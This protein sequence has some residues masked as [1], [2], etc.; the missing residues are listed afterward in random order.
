MGVEKPKDSV[1]AGRFYIARK[2]M[3][4]APFTVKPTTLV[5]ARITFIQ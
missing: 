4:K 2:F 1:S 3:G 5:F